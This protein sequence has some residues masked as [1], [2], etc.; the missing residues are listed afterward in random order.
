MNK[1]RIA[2]AALLLL[3]GVVLYKANTQDT[4]VVTLPPAPGTAEVLTVAEPIVVEISP[5]VVITGKL[6]AFRHGTKLC[7]WYEDAGMRAVKDIDGTSESICAGDTCFLLVHDAGM[8]AGWIMAAWLSEARSGGHDP[9][10]ET[11]ELSVFTFQDGNET[12][13]V[14]Y[15][16]HLDVFEQR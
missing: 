2:I 7:Q 16:P 15:F 3:T 9:R 12:D 6:P 1:K 4:P 10:K 5:P 13:H 11:V 8:P 14:I